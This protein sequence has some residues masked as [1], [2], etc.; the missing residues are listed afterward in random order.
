[1]IFIDHCVKITRVRESKNTY[2]F[3]LI[4]TA[5]FS[6]FSVGLKV[7]LKSD[8][9]MKTSYYY[10]HTVRVFIIFNYR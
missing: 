10:L 7:D 2:Y 5:L 3:V 8:L 6:L 1:M 9:E 4:V